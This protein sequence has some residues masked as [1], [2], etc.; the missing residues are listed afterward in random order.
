MDSISQK[1]QAAEL[2]KKFHG[3]TWVKSKYIPK[4]PASVERDYLRLM[5]HLISEG[6]RSALQEN[7]AELLEVLRY[8]ETTARTD[9]KSQKEKNKEKRSLARAVTLGEVAPQLKSVM[10][11]I[12]AKLESVFGLN[13][14][15]RR[16]NL[17]ANANRKLTVKEWKKAIGR[18]L[19]INIIDDFYDGAFYEG[20]LEQWV[21]DN[22]DLIK[23]I[24]HETLGRMQEVVLKSYLDGKSVTEIAKDIQH[25]YQ[26]T[27]SHARLLARDQTGKLNAQITRHQQ[28]SAGVN[29][30][31][32]RTA[33]DG[34]VRDSHRALNNTPHS[35][36]DPPVVDT[37]TGR[38]AH[39]G[40]DYQCRCVAI[41]VFDFDD[42][43]IPADGRQRTDQKGSMK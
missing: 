3:R 19:G 29:R 31:I 18:T 13:E 30:Y 41:P 15:T 10:D 26:V 17:I 2:K 23:T 38:R 5:N 42:L 11:K 37:K 4:Y 28:K 24:P 43:D 16:L 7:M 9:A 6:M 20:I 36:N 27:K 12:A 25:E 8:A 32:W 39:P 34:R 21:Q 40:E 35:W 33:G 22:V 14:L 1:A